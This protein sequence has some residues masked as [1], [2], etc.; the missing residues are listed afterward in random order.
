MLNATVLVDEVNDYCNEPMDG[1]GRWTDD[2]VLRKL[3]LAQNEINL[4][5]QDLLR[6]SCTITTTAS[7]GNY[8]LPSSVGKVFQVY[9]NT[10]P[11]NPS[12]S[13][14]NNAFERANNS[15]N[16]LINT[17]AT[18]SYRTTYNLENNVL[19]IVPAPNESG[20]L[21]TVKGELLLTEMT[22]SASS[23]PFE[24]VPYLAKAQKILILLAASDLTITDGD[25]TKS[26]TLRE[27]GESQ[28]DHLESDWNMHKTPDTAC[29]I[30]E[31]PLE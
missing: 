6:T 17:P 4:K 8:T 16:G 11:L 14:S 7:L 31:R 29:V 3:N 18:I 21:I 13:D 25:G 2:Q 20:A 22:N 27:Q 10:I 30:V 9:I 23:Y 26:S 19:N 24:N 5:V 28:L 1:T 12:N 15:L